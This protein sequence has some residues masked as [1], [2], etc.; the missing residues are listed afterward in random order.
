MVVIYWPTCCLVF[1]QFHFFS[2]HFFHFFHFISFLFISFISFHFFSFH[3]HSFSFRF[4]VH[5]IFIPF[6]S[7]SFHFHSAS[8]SIYLFNH[9]DR[10]AAIP[11]HHPISFHCLHPSILSGPQSRLIVCLGLSCPFSRLVSVMSLS[12]LVFLLALSFF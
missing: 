11:F 7:F 5:F 12:R 6:H 8:M 3:F 10:K 1:V 9:T 4:H 2:F